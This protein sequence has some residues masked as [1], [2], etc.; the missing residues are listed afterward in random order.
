VRTLPIPSGKEFEFTWKTNNA[1]VECAGYIA[2]IFSHFNTTA[3][4]PYIV[5]TMLILVAPPLFAAS[6][7]MTLGRV[8]VAL[9]S[10]QLSIIPVRFLT[11]TFVV[12]DVISFLLQCGG[13]CNPITLLLDSNIRY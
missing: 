8:M 4:G 12:G 9:N 10:Q 5:Q 13:K 7:Y 2:R 3:L 6:I 1:T 11:K